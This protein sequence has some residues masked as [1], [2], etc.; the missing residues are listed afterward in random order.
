MGHQVGFY[1]TPDDLQGLERRLREAGE[2]AILDSRSRRPAPARLLSTAVPEM[3]VTPLRVLL[4]RPEDL[5]VLSFTEVAGRGG[6]S[7]DAL[8]SPVMELDRCFYDG[9]VLRRGRLYY[10]DGCYGAKGEWVEKP[11]AFL[12]WAKTMLAAARRYLKKHP[13]LG[14]YAGPEVLS[15]GPRAK[16]LVRG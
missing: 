3:G 11:A 10:V 4:A 14:E 15:W 12:D 6:W 8:R 9:T 13:D 5:P 2:I 7:V 1:L 16:E